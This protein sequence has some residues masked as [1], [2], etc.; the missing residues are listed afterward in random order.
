LTGDDTT[1]VPRLVITGGGEPT[2][3]ELAAL[4]VAL[5]PTTG[6]D[7]AG[8]PAPTVPAWTRAALLEGTGG[9]QV[10]SPG[11]LEGLAPRS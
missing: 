4:V 10:A 11:G 5:T 1:D 6:A 9:S 7:P 2:P 3:D 8:P